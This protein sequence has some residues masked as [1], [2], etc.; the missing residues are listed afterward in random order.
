[1]KGLLPYMTI[2]LPH[3]NEEMSWPIIGRKVFHNRVLLK[4]K[5]R[6]NRSSLFFVSYKIEKSIIHNL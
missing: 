4:K 5:E 2:S 6:T 1:M 3:R